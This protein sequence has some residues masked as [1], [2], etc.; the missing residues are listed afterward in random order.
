MM[1]ELENGTPV[2]R[3]WI[4]WHALIGVG[5]GSLFIPA[6]GP[7]FIFT[8]AFVLSS[9]LAIHGARFRK[10]RLVMIG[11]MG[12]AVAEVARSLVVWQSDYYPATAKMVACFLWGMLAVGSVMESYAVRNRG[13]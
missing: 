2:E 8:I 11:L 13:L 1:N 10:R 12:L 7:P 6:S 3:T 4:V 9:L 5:A